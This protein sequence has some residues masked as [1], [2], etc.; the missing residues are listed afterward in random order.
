MAASLN[1]GKRGKKG[2]NID[3]ETETEWRENE[4][5][6]ALDVIYNLLQ[7]PLHRLWDPPLADDAFVE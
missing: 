5:R 2:A 7:L 6:T 4:R 1:I 3:R